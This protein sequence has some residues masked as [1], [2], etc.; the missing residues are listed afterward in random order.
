[1][2][3]GKSVRSI[4]SECLNKLVLFGEATYALRSASTS[5]ITTRS[6]II[7][8]WPTSSSCRQP[9]STSPDRSSAGS[10]STDFS[11][12][13]TGKRPETPRS[14]FVHCAHHS[15]GLRRQPQQVRPLVCREHLADFG[16]PSGESAVKTTP[17]EFPH[18]TGEH[19]GCDAGVLG[20]PRPLMPRRTRPPAARLDM[21]AP[22]P[23]NGYS[24]T[25]ERAPLTART[26][27]VNV[28]AQE[29]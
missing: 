8:S 21:P 29:R 14:S 4:K 25:E 6:E 17:I 7:R 3:A 15:D 27:R 26:W 20:R 5:R 11:A 12:S 19:G 1:M 23:R 9:T 16:L 2:V 28:S 22:W 18:I 24:L 13:A 10:A